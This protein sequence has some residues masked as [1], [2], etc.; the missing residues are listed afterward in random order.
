MEKIFLGNSL[1]SVNINTML[2]L[3][4]ASLILPISSVNP[5]DIGVILV[6]CLILFGL[7]NKD[8]ALTKWDGFIMFLFYVFYIL[9]KVSNSL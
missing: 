5:F 3:G 4:L 7:A 8:M 6:C 9:L 2:I 1:G